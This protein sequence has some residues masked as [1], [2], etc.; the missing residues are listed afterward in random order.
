MTTCAVRTVCSPAWALRDARRVGAL[1]A[2]VGGDVIRGECLLELWRL[3]GL[4]DQ[5]HALGSGAGVVEELVDR[6][7]R[8]RVATHADDDPADGRRRGAL[9][10]GQVD[11]GLQVAV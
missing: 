2:W 6:L 10:Y 4:R 8:V 7:Q 3:G 11:R 9:G 1:D 5:Q